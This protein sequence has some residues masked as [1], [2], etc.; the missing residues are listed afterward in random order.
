VACE[1]SSFSAAQVTAFSEGRV[2]ECFGDAFAAA[3]VHVRTPTIARGRMLLFDD[4][5]EFTSR[6]GP[7]GRGYLRAEDHIHPDEWFFAGHFK[8][9]PCMPGTMM[10][11]GCLQTMAFYMAGLGYTLN[12]DGWRFEPAQEEMYKLICRGQ[13]TPAAKT[14]VYEV[15]V[16]EVID[17]PV[18]TLYADLLCTVDGLAAFYCRR[19]GLRLVPA[20]PLESRTALLAN[21]PVAALPMIEDRLLAVSAQAD[22]ARYAGNT[23]ARR[24][25]L[26]QSLLKQTS[27]PQ[28][29]ACFRNRSASRACGRRLAALARA[30]QVLAEAYLV[31]RDCAEGAALD[32]MRSQVKHQAAGTDGGDPALRCRSERVFAAYRSCA[33]AGEAAERRCLARVQAARRDGVAVMPD[34]R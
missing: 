23:P 27:S 26:K 30:Y 10:L 29:Q 18:P 33:V 21:C 11:E 31:D 19:M 25:D 28:I 2:V 16:E 4:V 20:F 1:R 17:G 13:V 12:R 7:W 24:K 14:V 15:F 3:Q 22:E 8:N 34:V 6:G 5:V 9:D 32:V